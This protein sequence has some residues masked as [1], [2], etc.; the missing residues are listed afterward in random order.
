[1]QLWG[2][3]S[4][5]YIGSRVT[6]LRWGQVSKAF[7]RLEEKLGVELGTSYFTRLDLE[8]TMS[9]PH[10]T[11]SYFPYLGE[12]KHYNRFQDRTTLY[13]SNSSRQ[14]CIYDKGL[15]L[16][17]IDRSFIPEH[18]SLM[19]FEARYK[20]RFLKRLAKN[21]GVE[22]IS[23]TNILDPTFQETLIGL[24][25]AEYN[26]I[27]KYHKLQFNMEKVGSVKELKQALE[28]HAIDSLGG[29]HEVISMIERAR[30]TNIQL[31]RKIA[32]K[33]KSTIRAYTQQ[34]DIAISSP[35]IAELTIAI[36]IA[37][38]ENLLSINES[39]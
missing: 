1:M 35:H 7:E 11:K 24:W 23:V 17:P 28:A 19:R 31:D 22:K 3:L 13:Y 38:I 6:S 5:F 29:V 2:S 39:Y 15:A 14:I 20:W 4:Q 18:Q 8:A 16:D 21:R 37:Y 9:L 12:H 27:P 33:M 32:S 36:S 34:T 26:S 10:K 30:A 25:L